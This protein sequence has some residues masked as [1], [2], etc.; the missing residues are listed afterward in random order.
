MK[1]SYPQSISLA[2]LP[3]PINK[4]E[5]LTTFLNSPDIYVKRD[6]LTGIGLSGNKVRKLEFVLAQALAE[7]ANIVITCG[8][9]QSNHARATAIS[10][11]RLGLRTLLDFIAMIKPS[12]ASCNEK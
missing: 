6:D 7:G 11:T 9:I 1:F 3:T 2:N 4:L 10:A 8:G 5:R 12:V